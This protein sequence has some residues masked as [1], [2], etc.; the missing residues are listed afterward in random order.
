[1]RRSATATGLPTYDELKRRTDAPPGSAWGLF[2]DGDEIGT[3]NLLTPERVAAATAAVRT[4]Q[5][6]NLDLP[7]DAFDP[8]LISSR[9]AVEHHLF[10]NN[11]YHRDDWV[12]SF[13]LQSGSQLDGL[14]HIGHP[15]H[16]FYGGADPERFREREPY[17]GINRYAEHGIV[18]RGVLLDVDRYLR[19]RGTPID[20]ASSQ[21][22]DADVL[23]ATAREQGVD[24]RP[25][26]IVMVRLGWIHYYVD[27]LDD[28]GRAALLEPPLRTPGLAPTEA[29][30]RW[31]WDN[32]VAVVAADNFA[33]EAWPASPDSPFVTERE[34]AGDEPTTSHTGLMHR[35]LIPLLGMVIGE[36]WAL[37]ELADACAA[38]GVWDCMVVAKPLNLVGGA[39]SPANA[40]AIR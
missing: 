14:R 4:G 32:G 40:V 24:L 12:D 13:Y 9:H 18:G 39:G 22:I 10:A 15:D 19:A 11:P 36:L 21:G 16:G 28:A 1:M 23:D 26:D 2:G 29:V 17:L 30:V 37:D 8:P 3:L 34:R 35:I 20:Q 38:D 27:E 25:G 31:L 6:V 5:V 33:L 7:L